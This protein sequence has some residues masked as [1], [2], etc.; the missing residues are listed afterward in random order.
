MEYGSFEGN[1]PKNEYGGGLVLLWDRGHWSC[2]IDPYKAYKKGHIKF[3]ILGE[4]LKGEWSLIKI[5]NKNDDT[6]KNHWLLIKSND[7]F[8][9][10]N[11]DILQKQPLS[12][13]GPTNKS[14]EKTRT[15]KLIKAL[16]KI[17]NIIES[18]MPKVFKPQLAHLVDKT[19]VGD[20]WLHEIKFDGYRMLCFI[21]NKKIN[22]I[23]RNGKDW[24]EALKMFFPEL[25]KTKL[26]N[27]ILD[28]EIVSINNKGMMSFQDLQA[29]FKN[30]ATN[31]TNSLHYFI[32]DIPYCNGYDLTHV[33]LM[34]RKNFLKLL[35]KTFN[36]NDTISYSDFIIGHGEETYTKACKE[37]FE[38]L[39]SKKLNGIYEQKRSHSWLKSKCSK[40]QEFVIGGYTKPKGNR[41]HF[42]AILIGY[43]NDK[44]QLIYS[45][46]VGTG[47]SDKLLENHSK[48]FSKLVQT[49]TPFFDDSLIENKNE[50]T[51]TKPKLICEIK[52]TEFT[53]EG[54]LRHPS[55][56]G[57]REDKHPEEVHKEKEIYLHPTHSRFVN[58]ES[59]VISGVKIN[60]PDKVLYPKSGLTKGQLANYYNSISETILP[61]IIKRPLSILRCPDG[62]GT[63]CFFQKHFDPK[64]SKHIYPISI[65]NQ[66]KD[67]FY[68]KNEQGLLTLINLGVIELH[69][70]GSRC[71]NIEKPDMI[72]FDL[73]PGP[74]VTWEELTES[75][76]FIRDRLKEYNLES[77]IKTTGG[78]G[79]HIVI[80]INRKL[81]W[82]DVKIIAK[83]FALRMEEL[84]PERFIS[85][86][87]K[88]KRQKKIFIDYLRNGRGSTTVAAYS[89]RARE[90]ASI[91]VP[92]FWEELKTIKSADT[93]TIENISSRLKSLK[94]DPWKDFFNCRQ[95]I[96]KKLF[97]S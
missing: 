82:E 39:I 32:F 94:Q 69:P 77:F 26:K 97:L 67:Y 70:W 58:N 5:K 42:G 2:T 74:S 10:K 53:K 40:R 33:S 62:Y 23:T 86:M 16:L 89:T 75:A 46:K 44:N 45:G 34:E 80:P 92:I 8:A 15:D 35:F 47:F 88:A 83:R 87:S 55:F 21:E 78:K 20:E 79:F 17:P 13:L 3:N 71:D 4:K 72:V 25:E 57:L 6:K 85:S 29:I 19:P 52:F 84:L 43:Y 37:L 14:T 18:Q 73:D 50:I 28:G 93:Y 1:I 95:S 76:L 66:K 63:E 41:K 12:V 81:E 7:K 61:F 90:N 48:L 49:K 31:T 54:I 68:I 30:D 64:F 60:H 9:K 27:V 56:V 36:I 11:Y 65:P 24:T 22:F 38:G 96:S 59:V 91:S 51:W